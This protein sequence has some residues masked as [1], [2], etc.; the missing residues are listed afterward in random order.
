[1]ADIFDFPTERIVYGNIT[2]TDPTKPGGEPV[3]VSDILASQQLGEAALR[4]LAGI[5][6]SVDTF[7]ILQGL[8][9]NAG[10]YSDGIIYFKADADTVGRFYFVASFSEGNAILPNAPTGENAKLYTDA[11]T[12]PTY[13]YYTASPAAYNAGVTTPQFN[14]D[15]NAY[16]LANVFLKAQ[17]NALN[18]IASSLGSAAFLP[19]SA[20]AANGV[21]PLWDNVYTKSQVLPLSGGTMTGALTLNADPTGNLNP[22]TLQYFNAKVPIK[23]ILNGNQNVGNQSAG[24][25]LY[26]VS[27]GTTLASANYKVMAVVV[28]NGSTPA[29]GDNDYT[30][31]ITEKNNNIIWDLVR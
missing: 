25:T 14:G 19:A 18:V 15:M 5:D 23:Q 27:L 11:V 6:Y 24:D 28:S 9:Y 22:V 30:L 21:V 8:N 17:I 20:T 26:T 10:V 31:S 2:N 13:N 29:N 16:R 3:F 4:A 12:R 7:F 1:M